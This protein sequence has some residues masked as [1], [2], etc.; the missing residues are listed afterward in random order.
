[1]LR[2]SLVLLLCT[3]LAAQQSRGSFFGTV[4]D[5]SGASVPGVKITITSVAT[6]T[7]TSTESSGDGYYSAQALQVGDYSIQVE[8]QGFKR[9]VRT[10]LTLQVDQRSQVD[11]KLDIGG[12]AETIEVKGEAALVDT[13]SATVGKV[14]ENRR[15][16]E[17]PL[18][19]RNA[20]ALTLL[21]PSV[22]SN[23][24]PTNSGFGDRGIQ[25]SS[26][27]INGGPNAMNAQA[28]DGGN[29]IQSYIGEVAISPAVD[30]VEEFKVQ[31]GTMSAEF[32]FT[33]GGVINM[34]TKAGTNEIH[35]TAYEFFRNDKLDARNTFAPTKPPFRYN[36]Y[37]G[38]L[39]GP[40]IKNRTFYFG[41]WEEY[42]WRRAEA[43]IGTFPTMQQRTGNFNDLLSASG[44]LIPVFDPNTTRTNPSGAGVIRDV[45][46][47]NVIPTARLDRIAQNFNQF[48]P[49]PNRTPSNAF[50]NANNY[51]R[52]GSERRSMRQY[53][54]KID[55]RFGDKN[56]MFGRYSYFLHKTDNGASGSTIYPDDTVAKR[57][58]ALN[59]KN[60]VINDIHT[61]TPTLLN[62]LRLGATRGYFP[63]IVRSFGGGWPQKLGFPA[64]HPA[65]TVPSVSNGLP[66]FNTGTA[67]IRGSINTQIFDMVTK[68]TGKHT[69]KFGF[70]YRWLQGSNFQRSAPSGSFNFASALTGN[71][72]N[73]AGTGSPYAS[74]LLGEVTSASITTHLGE[75]QRGKSYSWFVQDDWK[76]ARRLT[77]NLGIRWDYQ[78][79]P[80]ETNCGSTNFDPTRQLEA[81]IVGGTVFACAD[82]Q[83]R[84]FR[85]GD[86]NDFA[87]RVGLAW[88]LFGRGKTVLRAGYG[89]YYPSQFWRQNYASPN[90]FANTSTAYASSNAN[91]RA[92]RFQDGLPTAQQPIIQPLGR[93]LGP[94]AFLG[95]G[96]TMDE[97]I[98]T[99]PMSNQFS[100]SLQHQLP[101]R[102]LV[103]VSYSGNLGSHFTSG[104]WNL[105]QLDN[106]HLELG[107][108]LQQQV[109][110]P[111]AGRV[112]GALGNATITRQQSLLPFPYYQGIT[113][114]GP[115]M[116]HSS[117]HLLIISVEK[118]MSKGLTAMFNFT[119]GKIMSEGMN[120][121]VDFGSVEQT[122][123]V[124][125][126]DSK[127]NRR[128]EKSVDPTDV[129]KRAVVSLLYELP[130]GKG[131]GA[132]NKLI[133]GWQ[134][135]TIG[136]M[137][138][139]IPVL[140]TGANNFLA[141][142]PNS[143]G[144]SAKLD[145][146][147]AARW[148][149]TD[150]FI[151]PPNF[152]YGNIGRVLPDVRG[153]GTF[154]WDLS[155]IKN[156]RLTERFNL[157]FRAEMFNFLNSVNLGLPAAGF[158]AGANGRNIS[159]TFATITNARD[160]RNIQLGLKLQ[161]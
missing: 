131:P 149:N 37:G 77:L 144:Q 11:F 50:T 64:S 41:N 4:T 160:A 114:R 82:G 116:S 110:N 91:A 155:F 153:P 87:P 32:G 117:S 129:S 22:K 73:Q 133:G 59:N 42:Q 19:G 135:N 94:R 78:T 25:L 55:H 92:F 139:G 44:Q 61:F 128:L 111:F 88:D 132:A 28:L 81:G 33:A 86:F 20:L 134:I 27:S 53:T 146:P 107:L 125:Y 31:S 39:G 106:R 3:P 6:N 17:L 97:L 36:Q 12:V 141:S 136:I 66:G 43:R 34:V 150:A 93:N 115:R 71:P 90:G 147:S 101:S 118:R 145:N 119:G 137:Q 57:D 104:G 13:G 8:K 5:A 99:T 127:F 105:N 48:Y 72:Q 161:F 51:G 152:T 154:N 63:F 60:V 98:G 47:G 69:L 1:M 79:Q 40:V 35:G 10:G 68:V 38:A 84:K 65:D 126:Q 58:D 83:G 140:V 108:G 157:Q 142:R 156:T 15:V 70:D 26:I 143:I 124:G 45:F 148:F 130:F 14:V 16:Q 23:A 113:V 30:A 7:S 85:P 75:T 138:T 18:N 159:G 62:E 54:I 95:Q 9:A 112:P 121:P 49:A 80:F 151:N 158:A 96:T 21:T 76:I 122:N 123:L 100:A 120:S 24:G 46:P 89:I 103:D 2:Y 56:S 102:I 109:P 67:G 74:F 52:L 29:N